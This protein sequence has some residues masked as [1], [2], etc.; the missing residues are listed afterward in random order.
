MTRSFE[1]YIRNESS[2]VV[3]A[4]G[5]QVFAPVWYLAQPPPGVDPNN[6]LAYCPAPITANP[7]V[8]LPCN[9]FPCSLAGA[10]PASQKDV[11]ALPTA[12]SWNSSVCT[13]ECGSGLRYPTIGCRQPNGL[14]SFHSVCNEATALTVSSRVPAV[15]NTTRC[16]EY[17]YETTEYG[18]CD[19]N[20][21]AVVAAPALAVSSHVGF[22]TR[23]ATCVLTE[24]GKVL[25]D[26]YCYGILINKPITTVSCDSRPCLTYSL[27][28]FPSL[29]S[30][31]HLS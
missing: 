4:S 15:C 11:A 3:D 16:M 26:T 29:E 14:P 9:L 1:C 12:L 31:L 27:K 2:L 30:C 19:S 20:C 6:L 24:D 23:T 28:V 8:S 17:H 18:S 22:K 7:I 21:S 10:S 13:E 5:R 25:Y